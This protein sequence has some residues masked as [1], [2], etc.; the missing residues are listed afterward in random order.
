PSLWYLH[1]LCRQGLDIRLDLPR[2]PAVARY[3]GGDGYLIELLKGPLRG[4]P[5]CMTFFASKAPRSKDGR[6]FFRWAAAH[7]Q[8]LPLGIDL[9]LQPKTWPVDLRALIQENK[10]RWAR[11]PLPDL[12]GMRADDELDPN[13]VPD[14][15]ACSLVNF[16]G[17]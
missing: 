15:Y 17:L 4:R 3:Y 2:D 16:G 12:S 13:Y 5:V 9:R 7:Y 8:V 10:S 14:Q 6:V 11:M 1:R